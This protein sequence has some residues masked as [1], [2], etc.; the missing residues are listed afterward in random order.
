MGHCKALTIPVH[1]VSYQ[2]RTMIETS[3]EFRHTPW[4][5]TGDVLDAFPQFR[6]PV[7]LRL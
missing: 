2:Y 5:T 1:H 4:Q 7:F 6:E 3:Q